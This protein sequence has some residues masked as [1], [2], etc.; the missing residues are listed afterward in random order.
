MAI[1]ANCEFKLASVDIRAAFLEEFDSNMP[2]RAV[3]PKV[4]LAEVQFQVRVQI[5]LRI[6]LKNE[7]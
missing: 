7:E 2:S 5:R 6:L 1:A 3:T 4:K